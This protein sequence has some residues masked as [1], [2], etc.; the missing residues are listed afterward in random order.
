MY[1]YVGFRT[2]DSGCIAYVTIDR[3]YEAGCTHSRCYRSS[4]KDICVNGNQKNIEKSIMNRSVDATPSGNGYR[5][6]GDVCKTPRVIELGD[7]PG[8]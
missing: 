7:G 3:K 4:C 5:D 6:V 8:R 2:Y 1:D